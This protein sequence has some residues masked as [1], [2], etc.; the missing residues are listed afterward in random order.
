VKDNLDLKADKMQIIREN[1][2]KKGR[3]EE[4]KKT[5]VLIGL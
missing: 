4:R 1:E 3:K 2:R 5:V